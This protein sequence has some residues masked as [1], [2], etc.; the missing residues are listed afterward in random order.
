[1]TI[2][3]VTLTALILTLPSILFAQAIPLYYDRYSFLPAPP[4]AYQEGLLGF[5]NPAAVAYLKT[6]E[7]KFF[8][9]TEGNDASSFYNWG[10]YSAIPYL[11]FSSQTTRYGSMKV[12]DYRISL[13]AG[14]DCFAF[15]LGY[16]WSTGDG[17]NGPLGREKLLALGSIIRP[18]KYASIGM[19]QYLSLVSKANEFVGE[20]GIRPLGTSRLTL[21]GD[22]ALPR[23]VGLSDAPYSAGLAVEIA[24]GIDL[25]GRYFESE[26]FTVGINLNLGR[27][28]LGGQSHYDSKQ[29]LSRYTYSVRM[30]GLKPSIFNTLGQVNKRYLPMNLK[31]TVDYQK[32]VLFDDQTIRFYDLLKNIRAAANDPRIGVMALNIS[33]LGVL[34]EHA[35]EIREELHKARQAGKGVIIFVE[36]PQMTGYHLASIAD[37][38]VLDP[39][40]FIMLPGFNMGKTYFKGTLDK[41]GL[42]F[43]E[44]RFFKYKSA[45]EVLS[46]EKMS[47]AD[48]GQYQDYLDV[49]Y[50][51]VR[52]D[53]CRSRGFTTEQYDKLIDSN[54]FFMPEDA[55][56]L[57]LV[58]TLARWSDVDKIVRNFTG[59]KKQSIPVR[60]LLDNALLSSEWG[61]RPQVA[62]VYG[63]GECAMESG[64]KA[65][66]LEKTINRLAGDSRVKA[67]VFRVDSPGG[68]GMASDVVAEAI[69]K[70]A[71]KKP[72]VVSQGQVAGSGGYWI[73]MYGDSIVAGPTTITGSIGV[74]GGWLYDKGF[75]G[76]L[77]MT[78]DNV[79]RGE[80]AELG[81]GIRVPFLGMT[82]PSRNLTGDERKRV[83]EI[84]R[85]FYDSFIVR[86]AQGRNM[87]EERVRQIAEGHFY[88]GTTGKEIGLV[89]EVGGLMTALAMA[90]EKAGLEGDEFDIVEHPK[91]KGFLK[92][93]SLSPVKTELAE[94]PVYRYIKLLSERPGQPLPMLL[95]GTYPTLK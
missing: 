20:L 85:R 1:M 86:V 25:V 4:A 17:N 44:W 95:P 62:I 68:D 16:G 12:R 69:R 10:I 53:I 84:I 36:T 67:V 14:K 42:G 22:I 6:G 60:E 11:G 55:L 56:Q 2:R 63:L 18:F 46:R 51:T 39:Q 82:V 73:S 5:D 89:D 49:W 31:G 15:G 40:G 35:W 24:P 28:G 70:C 65:R 64:I 30:G 37:R 66:S 47:D 76:K 9:S 43:D 26:A 57:K 52:D 92:F 33:A 78:S 94:E 88:A 75:S 45:A 19:V 71:K 21:F 54:I 7:T 80:H 3:T 8:W 90:A 79:K 58:D 61:C 87:S 91:Y 74:I 23:R 59:K 48:R 27:F 32:Y 38:I 50:E 29:K 83:E 13:A 77:G 81:F 93:P 72:V 41:L 34:P